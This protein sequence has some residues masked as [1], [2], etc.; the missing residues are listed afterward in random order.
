MSELVS[1]YAVPEEREAEASVRPKRLDEFIAQHRV[2]EQLELLLQGAVRRGRPP[3]PLPLSRPP[4]PGQT[5][6]PPTLAGP[7]G[8][9]VLIP[10]RPAPQRARGPP[11]P[12][13][14]PVP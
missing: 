3:H 2:R 14:H 11:A 7:P 5:T 6:P 12:P 10:T 8:V 9:G 1:A 4:R 13:A